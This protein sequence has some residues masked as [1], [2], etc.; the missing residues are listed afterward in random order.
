MIVIHDSLLPEERHIPYESVVSI[1]TGFSTNSSMTDFSFTY[2]ILLTDGT[3]LDLME[4]GAVDTLYLHGI[5]MERQVPI[6]RGRIDPLTS[7]AIWQQCGRNTIAY[8]RE[9][10]TFLPGAE[11][12]AP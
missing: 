12:P 3:K 7:A 1:E 11:F 2:E 9:C 8:V 10:Y 5:L 6:T 4:F